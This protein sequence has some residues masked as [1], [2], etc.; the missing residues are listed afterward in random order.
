MNILMLGDGS[1]SAV[2]RP[3]AWMLN[4]G[5]S[6]WLMS[7]KNP[8]LLNSPKGY[9]F[10]P[11][12]FVQP[13]GRADGAWRQARITELRALVERIDPGIVHVHG[14]GIPAA[15]S[16]AAGVQPLVFSVWGWLNHLVHGPQIIQEVHLDMLVASSRALIVESP[17][18]LRAAR[19]RWPE[20]PRIELIPM[21]VDPRRFRP[22]DR[23]QRR[24]WRHNLHITDD[25]FVILSPRGWGHVYN[26]DLILRAFHCA[27]PRFRRTALLAVTRMG[28]NNRIGEAEEVYHAFM[29]AAESWGIGDLI[30]TLPAL[31]YDLMPGL[32]AMADGLVN[33][34]SQDA[35]AATLMEAA[36][37]ELPIV[38]ARLPAYAGTFVENC[39]DLVEPNCAEALTEALVRLVNQPPVE[40][41]ERLKMARGEVVEH[42]NQRLSA[43]RLI[44]LYRESSFLP[45]Q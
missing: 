8:Y 42:F 16:A 21:G 45:C 17:A 18:L 23:A 4:A 43:E 11:T 38:C 14:L 15:I 29:R 19:S 27:L 40:R 13:G 32:F 25:A 20:G 22:P 7:H 35:F 36:A 30:R 5:L 37:C 31:P 9:E 33:Y 12:D 3:L 6:V 10:V 44:E 28:R 39:S 26:H 1:A 34:P 2:T 24:V 41:L